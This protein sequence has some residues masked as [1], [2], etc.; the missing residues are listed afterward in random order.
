[1][2]QNNNPNKLVWRYGHQHN[3]AAKLCYW[4]GVV[5]FVF[6][7]L[8]ETFSASGAGAFSPEWIAT[9]VK[10]AF[11]S[12]FVFYCGWLCDSLYRNFGKWYKKMVKS[13]IK[14]EGH[15]I[16]MRQISV[17]R[18]HGRRMTDSY[19]VTIAYYS[20]MEQREITY[21]ENVVVFPNLDITKAILCDVYEA[22]KKVQQ[23]DYDG[24]VIKIEDE[25][26]GSASISMSIN[27]F[28]LFSVV[29]RKYTATTFGN[30]VATNFRY[31]LSGNYDRSL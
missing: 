20:L 3:G 19:N 24:E 26:D 14:C 12:A 29:H 5:L 18:K 22:T 23:H 11:F 8:V 21:Q 16:S 25:G 6:V 1:M 2:N 28:K 13:G 9:I 27:P 4:V 7:F 17:S 31:D 15:V 10:M 30:Q